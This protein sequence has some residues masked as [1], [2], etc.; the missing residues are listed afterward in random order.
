MEHDTLGMEL[1]RE[2]VPRVAPMSWRDS[3]GCQN[4]SAARSGGA[5]GLQ[6]PDRGTAISGQRQAQRI[7]PRRALEAGTESARDL[8]YLLGQGTSLGGAR[9][10]STVRGTDGR[11]ALGKFPS[12]ADKRDVIRGEVL[13]MRLAAAIWSAVAQVMDGWRTAA[14]ALGMRASDLVD[15]EPAFAWRLH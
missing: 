14:A 5:S 3:D 2:Q 15:F 8:Q 11:L 10:K 1:V 4:L 12:Q 13:A 6:R 9:P 7:Q